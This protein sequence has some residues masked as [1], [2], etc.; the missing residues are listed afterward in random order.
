MVGCVLSQVKPS[1]LLS[2]FLALKNASAFRLDP[3][4]S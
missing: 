3:F 1:E 2:T 4:Q